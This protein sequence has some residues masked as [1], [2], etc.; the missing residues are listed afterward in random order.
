MRQLLLGLPI[1]HACAVALA[2]ASLGC[3]PVP[4][5]AA[6]TTIAPASQPAP[7]AEPAKVGDPVAWPAIAS[8]YQGSLP[9]YALKDA[10]IEAA[11]RWAATNRAVLQW[12]Q[13]TCGCE[14]GADG[15][16]SNWNCYVQEEK[17]GG[18]YVWDPMSAG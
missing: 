18:E 2:V 1:S 8:P 10:S 3:A 13:C 6:P 4:P 15:H 12:F 9:P 7:A 11:Y 17:P 5:G 14:Q 16:K